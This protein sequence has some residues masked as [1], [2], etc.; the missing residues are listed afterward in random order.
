[1]ARPLRRR[2]W[3]LDLLLRRRRR[4]GL[5]LPLLWRSWWWLDLTWRRRRRLPLAPLRLRW[6]LAWSLRRLFFLLLISLWHLRQ[7]EGMIKWRRIGWSKRD[8]R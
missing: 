1:L 8:S 5:H 7:D 3:W 2:W 6:R 4:W